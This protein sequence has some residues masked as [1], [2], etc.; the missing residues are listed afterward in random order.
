MKF[1]SFIALVFLLSGCSHHNYI[2]QN[3]DTLLLNTPQKGTIQLKLSSKPVDKYS[4]CTQDNYTID[5]NDFHLEYIQT[6]S[7]CSW[8][9]LAE[10]FYQSFLRSYFKDLKKVSSINTKEFDIYKFQTKGKYFYLISLYDVSSNTFII[11][12]TGDI[13]SSYHK[14]IKL[15]DE[16]ERLKEKLD[17]SMLDNRLNNYF[18]DDDR[19]RI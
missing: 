16:N 11:D 17:E 12:Y 19:K 1:Y 14:D 2:T 3:R 8:R 9:G 15:L 10:G 6:T 5:E 18:E 7:S 4:Y 13:A